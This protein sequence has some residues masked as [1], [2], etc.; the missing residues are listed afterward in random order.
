MS[1]D[2]LMGGN[3]KMDAGLLLRNSLM[4]GFLGAAQPTASNNVHTALK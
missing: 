2:W 3:T 4:S 1:A